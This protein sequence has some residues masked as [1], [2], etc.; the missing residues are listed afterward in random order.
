[1]WFRNFNKILNEVINV[2]VRPQDVVQITLLYKHIK[3]HVEFV[4]NKPYLLFVPMISYWIRFCVFQILVH[5]CKHT[6]P[7]EELARK[8]DLSLLFSAITSWCPPH[9][10]IW[11]KCAAEILMTLSRHGLTP[12]VVRYIHGKVENLLNY[13]FN[14]FW[15]YFLK[16]FIN[17]ELYT[18]IFDFVLFWTLLFL[19]SF[20][21]LQTV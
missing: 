15:F 21:V 12:T 10:A 19:T 6:S 14:L 8:D 13:N 5:L 18:C 9:N 20:V 7:A 16:I 17:M 11:R 2:F 1:M 4:D 3:I